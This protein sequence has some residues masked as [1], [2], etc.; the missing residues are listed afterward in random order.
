MDL[1]DAI[2]NDNFERVRE[3]FTGKSP[4]YY[5]YRQLLYYHAKSKEMIDC[6]FEQNVDINFQECGYSALY[7][8]CNNDTFEL[9]KYLVTKGADVNIKMDD[10]TTCLHKNVQNRYISQYLIEH[11]ADINARDNK[12]KTPLHHIYLNL[13][14]IKFLVENGAD[15][16]AVDLEGYTHLHRI[17]A[18]D[19]KDCYDQQFLV[20]E[21][22][23]YYISQG[24]SINVK[25][26]LGITPLCLAVK[27]G[28]FQL[29]QWLVENGAEIYNGELVTS[30][31]Y[32]EDKEITKY[33]LDKKR[34][35]LEKRDSSGKN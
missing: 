4:D 12:G 29:V 2:E 25:D 10:G 16:H 21:I 11:G 8:M 5:G 26:N 6:L 22:S 14:T 24:V 15:V 1:I 27:Y 28:S 19:W 18:Y 35:E 23:K 3:I 7:L 20:I 17:C 34:E 9:A 33:L 30:L 31:H 13:N 32:S